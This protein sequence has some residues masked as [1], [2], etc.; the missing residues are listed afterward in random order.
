MEP[1]WAVSSSI[2]FKKK[3]K[4]KWFYLDFCEK[5]LRHGEAPLGYPFQVRPSHKP[6]RFGLSTSIPCRGVSQKYF[7]EPNKYYDQKN[8]SKR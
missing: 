7:V 3:I 5:F 2:C 4:N 8:C 1:S 6:T